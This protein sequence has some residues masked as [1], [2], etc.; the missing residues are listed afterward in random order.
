MPTK[1]AGVNRAI[2]YFLLIAFWI[3]SL[4]TKIH[5]NGLVYGLDFGLYHP[6]GTLYTFRTLTWS[7]MSE[8]DAG[9]E[10]SNWYSNHA[11]KF[12]NVDPNSLHFNTNPGWEI[13]KLRYLYPL[14]SIPF[15]LLFG[16][17]GM[18]VIPALSMLTLMLCVYR[19][20]AYYQKGHLGIALA[21]LYSTSITVCRWMY[22][23]TADALLTALFSI[24]VLLIIGKMTSRR[25][26]LALLAL[27]VATSFTRF[28]LFA[29]LALGIVYLLR[30]SKWTGFSVMGISALSFT[31]TLF[32]NFGPSVLASES[33]LP[34]TEKVLRFPLSCLR[35]AFYEI[36]ELVVL[37][38]YL[39]VFLMLVTLV[40]FLAFKSESANFF[41]AMLVAVWLTG[42][43]NGVIGVNF[44][45]QLPL[46]PFA[47]WVLAENFDSTFSFVKRY[48]PTKFR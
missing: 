36:A 43:L 22:V 25:Y 37:D 16:I 39:I 34:L 3:I 42:A 40:A 2:P 31:P 5:T 45:Y 28:A 33:S 18:L 8:V 38:R 32:S 30:D 27:V 23:N 12:V 47:A 17:S 41:L 7:G 24:V 21:F 1:F 19:I 26:L 13:Y 48:F 44:R 46:L 4:A 29:W 15:V 20:C 6:D 35:I 10:I 11:S 14:L 9:R